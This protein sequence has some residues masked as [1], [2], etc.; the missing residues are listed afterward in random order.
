[1]HSSA[2]HQQWRTQPDEN[3]WSYFHENYTRDVHWDK[4]V[5]ITIWNSSVER[6]PWF[7]IQLPGGDT[8]TLLSAHLVYLFII[9]ARWYCF[10]QCLFV[11]LSVWL[12][13]CSLVCLS[14]TLRKKLWMDFDEIFWKYQG[15]YKYQSFRFWK[16]SVECRPLP[17]FK[18]KITL[19]IS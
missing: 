10:W 2:K 6:R 18:G 7:V 1:M 4:E 8:C 12:F 16:L 9:S 17:T 11:Y 5:F 19:L 3:W 13:V 15:F 14:T